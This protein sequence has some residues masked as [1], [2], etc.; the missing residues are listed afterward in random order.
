[1]RERDVIRRKP[2]LT[3]LLASSMLAGLIA[4]ASAEDLVTTDRVGKADAPN[5]L[6]MRA[7]PNQSPNS[8]SA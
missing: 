3:A 8:P 1:M 7:N 5:V 4:A 6:T 2:F